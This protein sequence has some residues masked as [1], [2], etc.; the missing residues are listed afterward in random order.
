[1]M[2]QSRSVTVVTSYI[3]H[4][5][6]VTEDEALARVRQLRADAK[7]IDAFYKQLGLYARM[8]YRVDQDNAEL[9]A[10]RRSTSTIPQIRSSP[11]SK[12]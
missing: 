12:K 6:N 2:G 10:L 8:G 9:K 1:M 3:M 4:K 5:E 11:P 7:P